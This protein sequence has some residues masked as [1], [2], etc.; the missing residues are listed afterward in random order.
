MKEELFNPLPEW[1]TLEKYLE[2]IGKS[3]RRLEFHNGKVVDIQSGTIQHGLL[4]TNLVGLIRNRIHHT[5]A[6]IY[7][8]DRE[9]WIE[10]S[11]QMFYPDL[12][13]VSGKHEM[14]KMSEL[15]KATIN[16][17]VVY[18][19]QDEKYIEVNNRTNNERVWGMTEYFE[20]DENIPISDCKIS[21]KDIYEHVK[22]E[23]QPERAT[24][25]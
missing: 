11:N 7:S 23:N 16:P 14:K 15:V 13:I 8:G 18:V 17:S 1:A 19:S 25:F 22:F 20:D 12:I 10:E 4:R 24:E 3:E 2:I 6:R 21:L 5:D 9:V